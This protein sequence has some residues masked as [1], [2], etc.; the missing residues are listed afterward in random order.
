MQYIH[1]TMLFD[2]VGA[3]YAITNLT[4]GETKVVHDLPSTSTEQV[5][6]EWLAKQ[7]TM[8]LLFSHNRNH[9]FEKAT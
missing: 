9:Y 4:T 7:E 2:K 5:L 6:L 3:Y 8:R 1:A